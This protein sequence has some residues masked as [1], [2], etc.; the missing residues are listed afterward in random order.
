MTASARRKGN[1]R[2][3]EVFRY[4]RKGSSSYPVRLAL[5]LPLLLLLLMAIAISMQTGGI[6]MEKGQG[7]IAYGARLKS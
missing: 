7:R 1:G 6:A 3:G 4:L 5:G 2:S